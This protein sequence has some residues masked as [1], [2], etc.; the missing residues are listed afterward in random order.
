MNGC[1]TNIARLDCRSFF[2]EQRPDGKANTTNRRG[3]TRV[4]V[5]PFESHGSGPKSEIPRI[6]NWTSEGNSNRP[7][8][9]ISFLG[10]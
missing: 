7:D 9:G 2:L 3:L 8:D 5:S 10:M 4:A 1:K 6:P